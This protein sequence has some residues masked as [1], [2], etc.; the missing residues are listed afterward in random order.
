MGTA[1]EAGKQPD[2]I[3]R[4]LPQSLAAE[5][6]VVGSMIVDPRCIGEVATELAETDFYHRE[7][8]IIFKTVRELYEKHDAEGVDGLL[9][10]QVL[11]QQNRMAEIGNGNEDAG[12]A[13]LKTVIESVP[14]AA[15]ADYY[16]EIVK[17]KA[18]RRAYIA[19]GT[20]IINAGYDQSQEIEEVANAAESK[21]FTLAERRQK[22]N[23]VVA[24]PSL[25]MDLYAAIDK[26]EGKSC[27]GLASGFYELDE[28]T[29]GFRD[30]EVIILAARPSAGKTAL[31]LNVADHVARKE[32]KPTAIFSLEMGREML[33]ERM[34]CSEAQVD[35]TL[36][37]KGMLSME[38]YQRLLEVVQS[39]Q[40]VPLFIDDT[41]SLTPFDLRAKARR[42][43]REHGIEL[44]IIDYLQLMHVAHK[45]ESR[46]VEISEISRHVKAMARELNIPVIALSQLNRECESREDHRPRLS[47]LRESGSLEQDSDVVLF[48][49]REDC[50][51]RGESSYTPTNTAEVIVAKERNGPTGIVKLTFFEKQTRFENAARSSSVPF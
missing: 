37:R 21:L 36:V 29:G 31:A 25:M 3:S 30:G 44:I 15:N 23:E 19:A 9:V 1:K 2:A 49:H 38:N 22:P 13:Y 32:G 4:A 39:F 33:A 8:Q 6:A 27:P 35:S 28:I 34:L 17:E 45:T 11:D 24:I 18:L 5:A 10:R 12:L 47:D 20:D 26:R 7:H 42:L 51:H 40:G 50:Y 46:Q 43:R 48:L 14:S 16:A 41:S